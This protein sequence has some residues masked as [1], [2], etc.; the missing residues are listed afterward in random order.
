MQ[1]DTSIDAFNNLNIKQSLNLMTIKKQTVD[2]K[3]QNKVKTY[4]G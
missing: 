4:Q 3:V 2:S 1:I